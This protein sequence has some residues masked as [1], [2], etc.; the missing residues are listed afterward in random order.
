MVELF[1]TRLLPFVRSNVPFYS[2]N[3]NNLKTSLPV[4]WGSYE[5][6]TIGVAIS[7]QFL[8]HK[9]KKQEQVL[10]RF[11]LISSRTEELVRACFASNGIF[12]ANP[13]ITPQPFLF[14]KKYFVFFREP[15][16]L[17]VALLITKKET[18]TSPVSF[19]LISSRTEERDEL[20]SSR[21]SFFPSYEGL[22]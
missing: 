7:F 11:F 8:L 21:T 19:F 14:P 15:Y 17:L 4:A 9:K 1:Y 16:L 22:S 10:F 3:K 6:T 13:A 12:Y 20:S 18:G 2:N 5:P